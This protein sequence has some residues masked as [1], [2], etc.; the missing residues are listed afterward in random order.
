MTRTLPALLAVTSLAASALAAE[1]HGA[2][3][4]TIFWGA[5]AEVD[6]TD[7]GWLTGDN[8][9]LVT[10]DTYAWVGGDDVKLRLEA[11]GETHAGDVEDSELRAFVAWNVSEFWDFQAGI[12]QDFYADDLTWA[13]VGFHG[14]APY[15]FETDAHLFVSENGNA[16]LRLEQSIDLAVTQDFFLEPHIEVNLFAEDVPELSIGAGVSDLELGLQAR[17]ELS[18]KLAPYV[19]LVYERALGETAIIARVAGEDVEQTTLRVGLRVRL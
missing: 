19:D 6:G 16:A 18:R 11:E 1:E 14:L 12:R 5:G 2:H 9:T 7:A 10:W 3:E 15:F 8:G 4:P 13:A 17:Y